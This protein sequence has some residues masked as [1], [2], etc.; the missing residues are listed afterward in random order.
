MNQARPK[1]EKSRV[2]L[3]GVCGHDADLTPTGQAQARGRHLSSRAGRVLNGSATQRLR[4]WATE[5]EEKQ[6]KYTAPSI[7]RCDVQG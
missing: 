1:L 4:C 7:Q 2:V 5:A 6:T 3:S